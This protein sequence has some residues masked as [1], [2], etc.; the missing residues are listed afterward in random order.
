M[1][2]INDAEAREGMYAGMGFVNVERDLKP[3]G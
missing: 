1:S 2:M 3:P